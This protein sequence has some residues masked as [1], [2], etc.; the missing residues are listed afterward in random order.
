IPLIVGMIAIAL[1]E[2]WRF[3]TDPLINGLATGDFDAML[4]GWQTFIGTP[5]FLFWVY[6]LFAIGNAMLPEQHDEITWWYLLVPLPVIIIP[7]LI[8]DLGVLVDA[9]L[10]GPVTA[11]GTWIS[12][13]LVT[14]FVIDL[15]FWV[16]IALL[17]WL[18]SLILNREVEYG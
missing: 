11:L 2:G 12:T 6:L 17:E 5:D 13:A 18:F 1:I 10:D 9:L 15:F 16:F 14:V 7:L 3:D 8:L 4:A